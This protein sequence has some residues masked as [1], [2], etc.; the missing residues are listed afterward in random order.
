[1]WLDS[2]IKIIL[3]I[4]FLILCWFCSRKFGA[5]YWGRRIK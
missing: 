4:G 1:M 3:Y 2:D 5:W